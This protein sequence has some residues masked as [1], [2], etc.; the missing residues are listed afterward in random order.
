MSDETMEA[1]HRA[2]YA[3]KS[4]CDDARRAMSDLRV[5]PAWGRLNAETQA[6][7]AALQRALERESAH[8]VAVWN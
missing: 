4:A 7:V 5:S 8:V 3:A 6:H 2:D 1:A